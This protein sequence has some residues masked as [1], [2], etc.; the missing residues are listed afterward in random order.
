VAAAIAAAVI[1]PWPGPSGNRPAPA[2]PGAGPEM[3]YV[4]SF[5]AGTVTP[6]DLATGGTGTPI[7]VGSAPDAIAVTP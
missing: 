2:G 7:Q 6:I 4:A 1:G 5:G 3:A